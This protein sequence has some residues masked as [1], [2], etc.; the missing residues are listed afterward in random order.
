MNVRAFLTAAKGRYVDIKYPFQDR[1]YFLFGTAGL[2]SAGAAFVAAVCSGL[3]WIAAVA[4]MVSFL[5]MLVL[6]LVS[7][8]M[9]DISVNRV[10]C[11]MFLNFFMFP[12]LFWVTGGVNCGMIFY[13]ILGLSVAALIL[14]GKVRMFVLVFT[15]ALDMICLDLGFRYPQLA[16]PLSY[17][18]RRMDTI[19]SFGIVAVFIVAVIFIMSRE[20]EKEHK[21]V[22]EHVALLNHQ[23]ITDSLT[24]LYNQRYLSDI[25]ETVVSSSN[26][27]GKSSAVILMDIDDF[28]KIND[29]YGHLRGNQVLC[30]LAAILKEKAGDKYTVF[31]Y[32]GEEFLIVMPDS[33]R[34]D[35]FGLA[36]DIRVS[37]GSDEIL[38]QLTESHFSIS[39]GVAQYKKGMAI[40]DWIRIADT[41]MYTAKRN[42]KNQIIG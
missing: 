41:N 28:K 30:R 20:Y 4:S 17:E 1:L 16:Y 8:F 37:T 10:L 38:A 11:G 26:T 31:R 2:L 32:G 15:L 14:D 42:G 6:M 5:V 36:E 13:F 18:E 9:K 40:D 23:A 21:I 3:P 29:T 39:G 7:F 34:D 19:F 12:A 33:V 24:T 22:A 35:A 25:L 27:E